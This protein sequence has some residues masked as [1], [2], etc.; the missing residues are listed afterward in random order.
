MTRILSSSDQNQD[1]LEANIFARRTNGCLIWSFATFCIAIIGGMLFVFLFATNCQPSTFSPSLSQIKQLATATIIYTSDYDDVHP[2]ATSMPSV[3]AMVNPY[4]KNRRLFLP[5]PQYSTSPSFN[6]NT[7]G[8]WI[9]E[10]P[11]GQKELLQSF[12]SVVW[13]APITSSNSY[14]VVMSSF[15]SSSRH[16]STEKFLH[17]I[18]PQ[19][20][21]K[22]TLSPANYL[23][24][25]D[26]LKE[27]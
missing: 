10:Q 12:Q 7:A 21:R 9:Y 19:F 14:G 25:Q 16:V 5:I 2:H 3:R 6:F 15:D 13:Y 4:F 11:L 26:P 17:Y 24:D 20:P 23:A 1:D 18:Q 8:V 22:A 27:N